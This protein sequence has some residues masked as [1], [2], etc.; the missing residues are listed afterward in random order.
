MYDIAGIPTRWG[1]RFT[2]RAPIPRKSCAQVKALEAA[3]LII[4]GKSAMSEMGY[5]PTTESAAFGPTRNPWDPSRSPGG[6]SGGSA[7]AV[8]SGAVAMADAADGGGSIRIPAS[9]CGLF[10]MKPSRGRMVGRQETFAGTDVVVEHCVSRSVRD[11]AT[12]FGLMQRADPAAACLPVRQMQAR[13]GRRLRIGWVL[14]DLLGK[15][16]DVDVT[17]GV[18]DTVQLLQDL[19]HTVESAAWPIDGPKFCDE[20]FNVWAT[21][22]IK[23]KGLA[24]AVHSPLPLALLSIALQV[25]GLVL[26]GIGT[27]ADT[28][29]VEQFTLDMANH[30]AK[31]PRG[32]VSQAKKSWLKVTREY[33]DWFNTFD[34]IL[35]PVLST[36]PVPIGQIHGMMPFDDILDR[37]WNYMHDTPL[38]NVVGA[39]AMS[40]P[41]HW[42]DNDL[43][44]GMQ[45]ASRL[46]DEQTLFELAFE[47]EQA[48]PWS[49]R[50]PQIHAA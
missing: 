46:G 24:R 38:H 33:D 2:S 27:K 1:S 40:V 12:L 13:Q 4:V 7:A 18:N 39:P 42:T 11:S 14:P 29:M 5:I 48:R 23:I 41:L 36:A 45:F 21:S 6:S 34:V 10:G 25:T 15:M 8:A 31:L 28:T 17:K 44:V 19:G 20:F 16:P 47:L 9:A 35:S 43:P 49:G 3:G 30:A 26:G 50:R 37:L 32:S 22:A